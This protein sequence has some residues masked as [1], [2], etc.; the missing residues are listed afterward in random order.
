MTFRVRLR[1]VQPT[2]NGVLDDRFFQW[3]FQNYRST[4]DAYHVSRWEIVR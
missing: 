4:P 2:L 1:N 3:W